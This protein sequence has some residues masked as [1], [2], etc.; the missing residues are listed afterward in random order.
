MSEDL[1]EIPGKPK[2][3]RCPVMRV[4]N[5]GHVELDDAQGSATNDA[6]ATASSSGSTPTHTVVSVDR[7]QGATP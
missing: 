3:P 4:Q 2:R 7:T 5:A 6:A 1:A